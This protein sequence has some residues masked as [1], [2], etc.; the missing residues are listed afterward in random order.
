[1]LRVN[2][3]LDAK[4]ISSYQEA[5]RLSKPLTETR[6]QEELVSHKTE[7]GYNPEEHWVTVGLDVQVGKY[8]ADGK[9]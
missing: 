7:F 9:T 5:R 4:L 8:T 2:E 6:M 1:M 3:K